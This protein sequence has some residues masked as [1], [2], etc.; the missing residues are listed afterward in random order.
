M[1]PYLGLWIGLSLLASAFFSG[2]EIAFISADRLHIEVLAREGSWGARLLAPLT[3][4]PEYFI[5]TTLIGNTI[6]LVLYGS[7]MATLLEP[8]LATHFND[9]GVLLCQT[10]IATLL[11][12][13][14]G[15]FLPKSLFLRN[16]EG[17]LLALAAPFAIM[18][19]VLYVVVV[20]IVGF[21][22]MILRGGAEE[23]TALFALTDVNDYVRRIMDRAQQSPEAPAV[24]TE[25]FEKA[26]AF[27]KVKVR[28]CM[29]PRTEIVAVELSDSIDVLSKAFID[30]GHSKI[31][32][33]KK[34]IDEMTGYCH[35]SELFKK[36]ARI[37]DIL[38][39]LPIVPEAALANELLVELIEKRRSLALVVD[40]FGGTSGIVTLEDVI[41]SILGEIQDEHDT[42]ALLEVILDDDTFLLSARHEVADLNQKYAFGL[43]EG[44]YDTLGGYLLALLGDF[45]R[46]NQV[47]ETEQAAITV[48][49][50][51]GNRIDHVR[52]ERR[53]EARER[54]APRG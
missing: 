5:G 7:L 18:Y 39:E 13:F 1:D 9:V 26:V 32:V 30:S 23:G 41:E 38:Q 21:S 15:E 34:T 43:P 2:M 11:V 42:E 20:V 3:R 10:L 37:K 33:Y 4:K 46:Q 36:P 44:E 28:D 47:I 35:S 49:A 22:R 6:S 45:P 14:V 8:W 31:L 53:G 24:D 27:R 54:V 29:I 12:L 19:G 51:A 48:L 17:L 50:M 16:P 52:L 25:I 40:E